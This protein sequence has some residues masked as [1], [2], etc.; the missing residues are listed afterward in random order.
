MMIRKTLA[1]VALLVA[2]HGVSYGSHTV[3]DSIFGEV[4]IKKS[5]LKVFQDKPIERKTKSKGFKKKHRVKKNNLR[6]RETF[7]E[8]YEKELKKSKDLKTFFEI[9]EDNYG[10][11]KFRGFVSSYEFKTNLNQPAKMFFLI[12]ESMVTF[13][14]ELQ[15]SAEKFQLIEDLAPLTH[16]Y[17]LKGSQVNHLDTLSKPFQAGI[18]GK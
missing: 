2:S 16:A 11:E 8:Y 6:K 17:R 1:A 5:R 9:I 13:I 7:F 18:N 3:D 12:Q 14:S 4:V 10:K 15:D